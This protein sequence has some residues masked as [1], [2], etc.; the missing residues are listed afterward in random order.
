MRRILAGEGVDRKK[1]RGP[2]SQIPGWGT[3]R[4]SPGSPGSYAE[5]T[6]KVGNPAV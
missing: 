4:L 2:D 3:S 6:G 1:R 5:L